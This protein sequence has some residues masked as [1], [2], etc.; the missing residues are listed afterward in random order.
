M[1]R[2][3][4]AKTKLKRG[5]TLI[6]LIFVFGFFTLVAGIGGIALYFIFR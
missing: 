2:I 3:N 1:K 6:E 4:S 5:F